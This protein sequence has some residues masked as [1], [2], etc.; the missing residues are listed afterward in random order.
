[1]SPT[2]DPSPTASP[3]RPTHYIV[4][5]YN[6]LHALFPSIEAGDLADRRRW[7]V[8]QLSGF[9][10][11]RAAD[12]SIVF[13]AATQ[14]RPSSEKVSRTGVTV[15]FA[16]GR[17]SADTLIARLISER[18]AEV[19]CVVVSADYE[20]QR[21]ASKA[22]VRRM[23]PRELG[24][25]IGILQKRLAKG[26]NSSTIRSTL[27]DKVDLETWQKLERLRTEGQ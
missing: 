19:A 24:L 27:E 17:H 23:T 15:W 22:G 4:D 8:D 20:V 10:A 3:G 5:G 7:L 2:T 6:V 11:L 12:V 14:P 18:P 25:E 9:A 16:G 21:T 1:V 13:D 26:E